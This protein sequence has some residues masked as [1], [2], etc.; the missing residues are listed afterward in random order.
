MATINASTGADIIVP[1]NNGDTYRGLAGND[2][3]ILSN[4]VSG[5]VTIVDTDGANTIQLVDGLSVVSSKFAADSAQLTLSNGAV[6]T[7]NG[8][9][10]FTY[11]VGG[12]ITSGI[13]GSSNTYAQLASAMGVPSLPT[14]STISDGS[15][16]TVSGSSVTSSAS[17]Y[18]LSADV[19][20]VAEGGT[21]TYTITA[22]AAVSSDTSFTYN[23]AGDTNGATVNKA[24]SADTDSLSGSVTMTSGSSTVTF[25]VSAA[26]DNSAEGMEGIKVSVFDSNNAVIGSKSALISNNAAL[27]KTVTNL[28]TA[29]DEVQGSAGKD[30]IG[31]AA[32]TNLLGSN[33]TT[34][35]PGDTI[36]GGA[37]LDTLKIAVSGTSTSATDVISAI[38][39]SNV[40]TIEINNFETTETQETDLDMSLMTGVT[41]IGLTSSSATGDTT[42]DN[43]PNL[44]D[45]NY[46]A[47]YGEL[48]VTYAASVTAGAADAQTINISGAKTT[49]N[50]QG[51]V[52]AASSS[53]ISVLG[54]ESITLNNVGTTASVLDTL[55]VSSTA[56]SLVLTGA[57]PT[58]ITN[59]LG[60]GI[61]TVDL[62]EATGGA[63]LTLATTLTSIVTGGPG[64]DRINYDSTLSLVGYDAFNGGAGTDTVAIDLPN[65]T[66][67]SVAGLT[68]VEVLEIGTA[69]ATAYD[70]N[71]IPGITTLRTTI[72]DDT[73]GGIK[74]IFTDASSGVNIQV[75]G[76]EGVKVELD[77]NGTAD[78]ANI[79]VAGPTGLGVIVGTDDGVNL[80][81][82]ET[83]NVTT[84]ATASSFGVFTGTETQTINI[85]GVGGFTLGNSSATALMTVD[86]SGLVG[87]G[88]LTM[89]T[90]AGLYVYPQTITGSKNID[91]LIGGG[92]AD[93]I[94]GNGGNDIINGG[95]YPDTISGGAG[96]D[97]IDG[98][99][100]IDILNGGVGNDVF[101]VADDADFVTLASAETVNG[102]AGTDTLKFIE[103]ATTI[104]A[105]TDLYG[106]NSIEQIWIATTEDSAIT[107]DDTVF[108]NNGITNLK[109]IDLAVN[110]TKSV[111]G[112]L[113]VTASSLTAANSITVNMN[114]AANEDDTLVGGAGDDTFTYRSDTEAATGLEA[115]DTVTGGKGTDTLALTVTSEDI[116]ALGTN[117]VLTGVTGVEI[118][119]ITNTDADDAYLTLTDGQFVTAAAAS[120]SGNGTT[121]AVVG[122]VDAS[123]STGSGI[124][125]LDASAEDDSKMIITGGAG[126]DTIT[127]GAKADTISGGTGAD[128]LNGGAGIDIIIGGAGGD[129]LNLTD[130]SDFIGLTSVEVFDG[131]AGI[132]VVN[133]TEDA[134]TTVAAADLGGLL[135][136]ERL[137]FEGT[138]A[139][140]VTLSDGVYA[141]NGTTTLDIRDIAATGA[142][143]VDAAGVSATNTVTYRTALATD[144]IDTITGGAGDDKFTFYETAISATD[145]LAGGAGSDTLVIYADGD[146]G[147]LTTTSMTKFETLTLSQDATARAFP[148]TLTNG[149]FQGTAGTVAA[150]TV[151]GIVTLDASAETLTPLTISTGVGADIITGGSK[152][153]TIKSGTGADVITGGPGADIITGGSDADDFSYSNSNAL[154][155]TVESNSAA[156]DVI[157]DFLSG[158]DDLKLTVSYAALTSAVT[159]NAVNTTGVTSKTLAQDSLSGG[160]LQYVYNYTDGLLYINYNQDNLITTSDWTI[161]INQGPAP[162]TTIANGDIDW[163]ITG[164]ALADTIKI[165]GGT[166]IIT[167]GAGNDTVTSVSGTTGGVNTVIGGDGLDII[168]GGAGVD[169]LNGGA[170]VDTITGGSGANIINGGAAADVLIGGTGTGANAVTING[171]DAIDIITGGAGTN[172]LN[173]DAA[174]DIIIGGSGADTIDGGAA[175]DIINGALGINIISDSA[176]ADVVTI[177]NQGRDTVNV[178]TGSNDVKILATEEAL[179]T[180]IT[181]TDMSG[182]THDTIVSAT[183]QDHITDF[184]TTADDIKIS[185]A[186]KT[187][188]NTG[189]SAVIAV[190]QTD[191]SHADLDNDGVLIA[192]TAQKSAVAYTGFGDFSVVV[193]E[194]NTGLGTAV[195][196]A[197]NEYHLLVLGDST[198]NAHGVWIWQ[199]VDGNAAI[200]VGDKLGLILTILA[201]GPLVVADFD[202]A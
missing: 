187:L 137:T 183:S 161:A 59:A 117:I 36:D 110:G 157:T 186:L 191:G 77:V 14:G 182:T 181:I 22:N 125:V 12:N 61:K 152:S 98:D 74:A 71:I 23:V 119:T 163:T 159:I 34:I 54:V 129:T 73:I 192:N 190:L 202:V 176:D 27:E 170:G 79:S 146:L 105:A 47:G 35:A 180:V 155:N 166:N 188:L 144:T 198:A 70:A 1:S 28:T 124:L 195:T 184:A 93:T 57:A 136:V 189:K 21:I 131:G 167:A 81:E 141:S 173:G 52:V 194:L 118:I 17:S 107:L 148:I 160:R 133:F 174:A 42:F 109:I 11:D 4:A 145:V 92:A 147:S 132:D 19:N 60:A 91:T 89:G 3:Y 13:T 76:T 33:G 134:T 164:T 196:S 5:S 127:G 56:T 158:S 82:F 162:K 175:A 10:K 8:A 114:V 68:N 51:A 140:S 178:A 139:N 120:L 116:G 18:A 177:G 123:A 90:N 15:S 86:A 31:G 45:V 43:I 32:G 7:I 103:A 142:V 113:T 138:G 30:T 172:I 111:D 197:A 201:N 108:A 46:S 85:S 25:T 78:V 72:V 179:A 69:S 193:A 143:T 96:N 87:T 130:V 99:A 95:A 149:F 37:G 104:V 185:G 40:E 48:T 84:G 128:I 97:I 171:G 9:D 41:A 156:P 199:D 200:N 64:N 49:Y 121:A 65:L 2:T 20:S 100:G 6:I 26:A 106:L 24:G 135:G 102:G 154:G 62:T 126:A 16:G 101:S 53:L 112:T 88:G 94:N 165:G 67:T 151:T 169:V 50:A 29:I 63:N 75:Q 115:S 122:V 168:I 66:P 55:T 44:V 80:A 83:V 153:D 39:M 58:I 150:Q 38:T